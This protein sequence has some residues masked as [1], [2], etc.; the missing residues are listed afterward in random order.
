M[1]VK[2]PYI[3]KNPSKSEINKLLVLYKKKDFQSLEKQSRD[4]LKNFPSNSHIQNLLGTALAGQSLF[5]ES[6]KIFF[7]A[8]AISEEG[9]QKARI[10]NNIGVSFIKLDDPKNASKY[11]KRA[12][13][14]NPLNLSAQLNLANTLTKTGDV[15][16]SLKSFEQVLKLD[17]NHANAMLNYSYSL[18]ILGRFDDSIKFCKKAIKIKGDWG[19]AHRH[20]SSMIKYSQKHEHLNQMK[21]YIQG[22]K[23]PDNE[24]MHFL[25]ALSKATED[26]GEYK[27]SFKFL[28]EANKLNRQYVNF[29]TENSNN[30]FKALK[31]NFNKQ[32]YKNT[33]QDPSLGEGI[34]FVLG[35]PRSGTSLVEQILSSHSKVFGAGEIRFFRESISKI[36][37]EK[38]EKRF[39]DNVNLYET[40]CATSLGKEYENRISDLR[41]DSPFFVDKMPYNFM[42]IPLI[43][44]SLPMS[45]IILTERNPMDNCLS[46]FKKKF[47]K[48]NGYAYSLK[49]LGE[50]YNSYK[51]ITEE[52]K[53]LINNDLFTLNYEKLVSSQRGITSS[54]L[55]FCNLDWEESCVQFH[56]TNRNNKTASSVQVRQPLY[57]SSVKLWKNYEQELRPLINTLVNYESPSVLKSEK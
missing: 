11:L 24:R 19:K 37:F 47:G 15:Q 43:K 34:I 42:Y 23:L 7:K 52:W 49:E 28:K 39:P 5:N 20:L 48:G 45:S 10:L 13:K 21:S 29:S 50:Y 26:I 12:I 9:G 31:K 8:L 36:F 17:P 55:K 40:D 41:K 16:G 1:N 2:K 57:K 22:F 14:Q 44:L 30:Y 27:E 32:F 51:D 53:A 35:M 33:K 3:K 4:L 6:I 56:K 25:F 38:N 46:I 54:L 18:K